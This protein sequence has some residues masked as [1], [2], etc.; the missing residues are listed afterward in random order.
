M[1]NHGASLIAWAGSAG[2]PERDWLSVEQL[3]MVTKCETAS[4]AS[5]YTKT[6]SNYHSK[7]IDTEK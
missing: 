4:Y 5:V 2:I 7:L 6:I 3:Q 1:M